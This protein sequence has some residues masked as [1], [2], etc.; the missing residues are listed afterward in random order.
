MTASASHR[1]FEQSD[2]RP[3]RNTLTVVPEQAAGSPAHVQ[4]RSVPDPQGLDAA[5]QLLADLLI[6]KL[7]GEVAHMTREQPGVSALL[8]EQRFPSFSPWMGMRKSALALHTA[9]RAGSQTRCAWGLEPDVF[10]TPAF[11]GLSAVEALAQQ[12][13]S[14]IAARIHARHEAFLAAPLSPAG[15]LI[16][17]G[18][19][20]AQAVR[21]RATLAA[22][23]IQARFET[24]SAPVRLASVACGA[25]GPIAET[26]RKLGERGVPVD[27]LTLLDR[28]P[29][30][31]AAGGSI[32][33]QALHG[34][35]PEL[36][37]VDLIDVPKRRAV[38]LVP[39]A[40]PGW[41]VVDILGL[42]EYL[43]DS[44]A[45]ELARN[46]VAACRPGGIV[47]V[48]NMLDERPQ[49]AF[50]SKVMQWPAVIQRSPDELRG[51]L[52]RAGIAREQVT[53]VGGREA[54]IYAVAGIH[55]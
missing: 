30:A 29:M 47:V 48:A 24:R 49:Q 8:D 15:R 13:G 44:F 52:D 27:G 12:V 23:L 45:I 55:V 17:A 16:L 11:G 21:A 37:I 14:E 20:D 36:R 5:E 1:E 7:E 32:A 50:F 4:L 34:F 41:D 26:A 10:T 22:S 3:R 6:A 35:D 51:L 33:R 38:E 18:C 53:L 42:F 9:Y 46:A 25:A 19:L 40:G 31:L 2:V 28:D 54:P 39:Y 43:P